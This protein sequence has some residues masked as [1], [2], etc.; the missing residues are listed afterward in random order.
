MYVCIYIYILWM[1]RYMYMHIYMYVCYV[2]YFKRF[3][4]YSLGIVNLQLHKYSYQTL[5]ST[6]KLCVLNISK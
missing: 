1:Y 2:F 5:G 3:A 4:Q 6:K